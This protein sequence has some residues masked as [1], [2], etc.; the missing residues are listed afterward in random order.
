MVFSDTTGGQ[1]L[2]QDIDF[3][4]NSDPT[5]YDI[6]DKTRNINRWYETVVDDILSSNNRW[7]WD[8]SNQI[9]L[10]RATAQLNI[11]Q[12]QYN[13]DGTWL[14]VERV[15]VKDANGNWSHLQPID[16]ADL[17]GA[18]ESF[19]TTPGVPQWFDVDGENIFLFPTPNYTQAA[20]MKVFFQRKAVLF[21]VSDTTKSPGFATSFHRILSLGAAYDWCTTKN[22]TKAPNLMAQIVAMREKLKGFYGGRDK[23]EHQRITPSRNDNVMGSYGTYGG[24]YD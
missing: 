2:V 5:T 11:N 9:D 12:Q 17:G 18:Y 21:T 3:Y 23:Y 14:I 16:Q 20:S 7:Q 6:K 22:L 19:A 13:F 24:S 8:D 1:G 4:A 10:P 15:D